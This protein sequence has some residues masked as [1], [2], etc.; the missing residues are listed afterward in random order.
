M[1]KKSTIVIA[2]VIFIF[3]LSVLWTKNNNWKV[4]QNRNYGYEINYPSFLKPKSYSESDTNLNFV[5]FEGNNK[6]YSPFSVEVQEQGLQKNVDIFRAKTEGHV[7]F[8]L[9]RNEDIILS[10]HSAK[11]IE[12]RF[13]ST[14]DDFKYTTHTFVDN[15]KYCYIIS[16][17]SQTSREILNTFKFIE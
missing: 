1:K 5:S 17:N 3:A 11:K 9:I 8:N 15:G 13:G 4:Y 7:V 14:E 16:T 6:D 12:Y 2:I 10:G